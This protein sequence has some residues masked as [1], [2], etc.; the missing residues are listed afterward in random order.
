MIKQVLKQPDFTGVGSAGTA[1]VRIPTFG[2]HF[3]EILTFFKED[4]A[5]MSTAEIVAAVK[6]IRVKINGETKWDVTADFLAMIQN[7]YGASRNY[8]NVTGQLIIDFTYPLLSTVA[9]RELF[10]IGTNA[11]THLT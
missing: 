10:A 5:L 11:S 6:G 9:E 3:Q 8:T 2:R 1:T 4:N 7:Y